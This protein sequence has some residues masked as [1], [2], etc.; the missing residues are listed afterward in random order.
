MGWSAFRATGNT[1]AIAVT[2]TASAPVQ[3]P[4]FQG[5]PVSTN[6]ILT[7]S[8][9]QP[10]FV[11][12]GTDANNLAVIPVP[13]TGTRGYWLGPNGQVSVTESPRAWFSVIAPATTS[14]VY[15]TPG[16]GI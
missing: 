15:I 10:V 2:T 6:Y 4:A 7:N 11:G 3:A 12:V 8:T 1:I 16:D 14:T 13:G 9:A 5:E